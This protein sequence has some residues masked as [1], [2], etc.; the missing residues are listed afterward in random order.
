MHQRFL[1]R[2]R[3]RAQARRR[4]F[5]SIKEQRAFAVERECLKAHLNAALAVAT[6]AY[7]MR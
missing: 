1:F 2:F 4:A 7:G 5:F 3:R 6:V